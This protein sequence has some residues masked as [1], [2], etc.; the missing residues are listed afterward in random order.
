MT[1]T[2]IAQ[3]VQEPEAAL[4]DEPVQTPPDDGGVSDS[5]PESKPQ[6]SNRIDDWVDYDAL[7]D[8]IRGKVQSRIRTLE[9]QKRKAWEV[10]D[11]LV[12]DLRAK[13]DQLQSR[14]NNW[15]AGQNAERVQGEINRLE[16]ELQDALDA[17][18]ARKAAEITRRIVK[19]EAGTTQ[20]PQRREEPRPQQQD[21]APISETDIRT[22]NQWAANRPFAR[23]DS[24]DH[25]WTKNELGKLYTD[26]DW[27]LA[28]IDEKL[29]EVDRRYKAKAA[30]K[31]ADVLTGSSD[32][33][34]RRGNRDNGL[35]EAQKAVAVRM[36][37]D[38]KPA[39]AYK[40]YAEG[41]K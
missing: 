25:E 21:A 26:P 19:L 38:L 7:P 5:E 9:N 13:H 24:P 41:M 18:D 14:L 30:P 8:E 12:K 31:R 22:I 1:D 10:N 37:S 32:Q 16:S 20:Q 40:A 33:P 23:P 29:R 27:D 2:D 34:G 28:P 15:E 17:A 6:D 35:T 3:E 4:A 11:Q 39:D 36:F